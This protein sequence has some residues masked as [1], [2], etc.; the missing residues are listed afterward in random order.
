MCDCDSTGLLRHLTFTEIAITCTPP[1]VES[2]CSGDIGVRCDSQ[3][4]PDQIVWLIRLWTGIRLEGSLGLSSFRGCWPTRIDL[5]AEHLSGKVRLTDR[6]IL[7]TLDTTCVVH[8]TGRFLFII[9][10]LQTY[11]VI[12]IKTVTLIKIRQS[13]TYLNRID[14]CSCLYGILKVNI[15]LESLRFFIIRGLFNLYDSHAIVA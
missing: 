1:L 6:D 4:S 15:T 11:L 7:T 8:N 13:A 2:D 3:D 5:G 12:L 9:A 14:D 10:E